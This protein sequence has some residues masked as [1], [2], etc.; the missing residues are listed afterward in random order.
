METSSLNILRLSR[1]TTLNSTFGPLV[2]LCVEMQTSRG[3]I[4]AVYVN[5][6]GRLTIVKCKLWQN[7]QSRREVVSQSL[8]YVDALSK[9]TYSDL[10]RQVSMALERPGVS[11]YELFKE[12]SGH[13]IDEREFVELGQSLVAGKAGS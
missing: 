13:T 5:E 1:S 7:P 2:P 11:P 3:R 6:H 8:D 4:D 9:W 12:K 10:Q